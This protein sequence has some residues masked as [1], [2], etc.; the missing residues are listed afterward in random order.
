[1]SLTAHEL[2][3][4]LALNQQERLLVMLYYTEELTIAEVAAV[5]GVSRYEAARMQR[6]IAVR[7]AKAIAADAA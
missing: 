5:L 7:A 3:D 4:R 6:S 1:M 2:G